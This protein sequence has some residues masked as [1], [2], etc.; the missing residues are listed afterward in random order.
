MIAV[1]SFHTL[2]NTA[3]LMHKGSNCIQKYKYTMIIP[4]FVATTTALIWGTAKYY[5]SIIQSIQTLK[6][7][8]DFRKIVEKAKSIKPFHPK[9]IDGLR[10]EDVPEF[11]VIIDVRSPEEYANGHYETAINIPH[12]EFM[13]PDTNLPSFV[14]LTRKI[15]PEDSILFY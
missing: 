1:Q 4:A 8:Q 7:T 11:N 6:L 15:V 13:P 12:T 3:Y 2:I 9:D 10:D 14:L 5:K